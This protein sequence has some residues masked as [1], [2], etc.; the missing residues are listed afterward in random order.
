MTCVRLDPETANTSQ[1]S[2]HVNPG[3]IYSQWNYQRASNKVKNQGENKKQK[4]YQHLSLMS[5]FTTLLI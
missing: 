5:L 4:Q 2:Y 3:T 1:D